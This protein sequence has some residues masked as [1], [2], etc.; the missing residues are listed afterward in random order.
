MEVQKE[1]IHVIFSKDTTLEKKHFKLTPTYPVE[2]SKNN[3][4]SLGS[5]APN[6]L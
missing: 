5:T 4:Y 6:V 2:E 3:V 1:G